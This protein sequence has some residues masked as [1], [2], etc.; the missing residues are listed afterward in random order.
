LNPNELFSAIQFAMRAHR[1]QFRKGTSVPYIVHPLAVGRILA[2]AGCEQDIVIAG[3]LHDTVEDT[4]VT[5]DEIQAEFGERVAD[6]VSAVTESDRSA[7]WKDRKQET[8]DKLQA[9]DDDVLSIALADK[10]DNMRSIQA[11]LKRDGEKMWKKFNRPREDQTWYF[12][13][14]AACFQAR[15]KQAPALEYLPEFLEL[16]EKV[17]PE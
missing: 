3:F 8:L 4:A 15:I 6:M 17:F 11:Y 1:G 16:V 9:A 13:S 10:I 12:R 14:L 2:E 7:P 5:L